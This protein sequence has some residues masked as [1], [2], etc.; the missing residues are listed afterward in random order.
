MWMLTKHMEKSLDCN[1]TRMLRAVLNKSWRQHPIKQQLYDHPITKPIQNRRTRHV[2]HC[3]RS[4]DELVNNVLL[5]TPSHGQ[6][7]VER[8]AGSDGQ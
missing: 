5:W 2:G 4:N 7:K 1:Y 6:A 3:W 8:P